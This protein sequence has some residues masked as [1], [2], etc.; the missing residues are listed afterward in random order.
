MKFGPFGR[1]KNEK[2]REKTVEKKKSHAAAPAEKKHDEKKKRVYHLF[3]KKKEEKKKPETLREPEKKTESKNDIVQPAMKP[4]AVS[5]STDKNNEK[6][7]ADKSSKGAPVKKKKKKSLPFPRINLIPRPYEEWVEKQLFFSGSGK[8]P[9]KVIFNMAIISAMIA[10]GAG[11]FFRTYSMYII[12]GIFAG[13]FAMFNAMLSLSVDRRARFVDEILPDALLL[14]SANIRA[15]YIPSRA[16]I[17]S[18]RKE[19]GPL[20]IA[21]R[22]AGKEIMT[23]ASLEDGLREIPKKIRS[24]DLERTIMLIIE[25]I[26]GGGQIV[27]L[28]E[29]TA[30]DIRRRQAISKEISANIMMYAIFIA[31][32]GCLG[33]PGLY[34]LSGYLTTT[35]SQLTPDM[36]MSEQVSSKVSFIQMSGGQVSPEFL[37]MFSLGAILITTVFG[38]LILGMIN[39]GKEKDGIKYAPILSVIAL[40]VFFGATFMIN[41]MFASLL[42]G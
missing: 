35:M 41:M 8:T 25:G 34:A 28:L 4:E 17:L 32:A 21:I 40:L 10:V 24:K 16:L 1:K 5:A 26:R 20:S 3:G 7:E 39:S 22:R 33:A 13:L 30:I 2:K 15:G 29:E 23:G 6:A 18:A 14:L 36:S 9:K 12:P 27:T 42:P 31:F 38:G 37:F 11:L 19:F